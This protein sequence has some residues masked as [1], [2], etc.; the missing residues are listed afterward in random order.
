[1]KSARLKRRRG[2]LVNLAIATLS[3]L[4]IVGSA[5]FFLNLD[6]WRIKNIQVEGNQI[7]NVEEVR[8]QV[9]SNI[10]GRYLGIL[11]KD[12]FMIYPQDM[13]AASLASTLPRIDQVRVETQGPQTLQVSLT[14][15]Q[16][17]Y[18]W[19]ATEAECLFLDKN[20]F[21]F[22]PAPQF[23]ENVYFQLHGREFNDSKFLE[24]VSAKERLT[25]VL[26]EGVS[27]TRVNILDQGDV[28][29][30]TSQGWKIL[31]NLLHEQDAMATILETVLL[32]LD[33]QVEDLKYIDLRLGRKVFYK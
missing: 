10:S 20:G 19:C 21:A 14:E 23:S 26:P 22:A 8:S 18:V 7:I 32:N 29:F 2:S 30:V 25:S 16:P 33:K 28:E 12:N 11:P 9:Q 31:I 17:A 6:S 1:M 5:A 15:R 27:L 4:V 3:L 24:L 13:I